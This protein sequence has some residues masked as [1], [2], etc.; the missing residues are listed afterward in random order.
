MERSVVYV[1]VNSSI[2]GMVKVGRTTRPIAERLT[3]LSAATGVP[4]P[5]VL[6]FEQEFADCALAERAIHAELDRLGWRIMPN[7]EFFRGSPGD[8]IRIIQAYAGQEHRDP[9]A[10]NAA[11]GRPSLSRAEQAARLLARA[12]SHLHGSGDTL[13]DTVEAARLYQAAANAGSLVAFERLAGLYARHPGGSGGRRRAIRLLKQGAQAGNFYCLAAMA[14]LY[15]K[16]CH[17]ANFLK[18]WDQFFAG[19]AASQ[20]ADAEAEAETGRFVKA[21]TDYIGLCLDLRLEPRNLGAMA[22]EVETILLT[23][24]QAIDRA[25]DAEDLRYRFA[26]MLRWSYQTLLPI[27][28]PIHAYATMSGPRHRWWPTPAEEGLLF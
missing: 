8:I 24:L 13:Q 28:A 20:R 27:A 6:A 19:W 4:T 22:C 26:R 9:A 14:A 7:R 16:E 3:E 12:D 15:A 25:G 10:G 23:L 21:C 11:A 18:A 2:P 1:M 5:F 17:I